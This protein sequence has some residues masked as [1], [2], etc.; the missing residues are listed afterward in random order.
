MELI[1]HIGS[2]KTGST[3]LQQTLR[4]SENYLKSK[5]VLYPR[6]PFH[7]NKQRIVGLFSGKV[8][9]NN[10]PVMFDPLRLRKLQRD[11]FASLAKQIKEENIQRLILS[12]ET[13][14]FP[15]QWDVFSEF[16]AYIEALSPSKITV[17]AYVRKPS[18][19]YPSRIQ[20][21]IK[22]ASRFAA[23]TPRPVRRIFEDYAQAFQ[24]E[25]IRPRVFDRSCLHDGDIVSDFVTEFLPDMGIERDRLSEP[26]KTNETMSAESTCLVRDYREKFHSNRENIF[27]PDT[28]Y[29]VRTLQKL[30][31]S[32][33]ASR[34]QIYPHIAEALDYQNTDLLWLRDEYGLEFPNYDYA[35][36][37]D[38]EREQASRDLYGAKLK[39]EEILVTDAE[40]TKKIAKA[41]L[42]TEWARQRRFSPF[43]S[44]KWFKERS[45][46][47]RARKKW[48]AEICSE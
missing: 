17:A 8:P 25:N 32:T 3:S 46:S 34:P 36:L 7:R 22:A 15:I 30:D 4:N 21:R 5:G 12:D 33:G 35:R 48:L 41:L 39:I 10:K 1:L 42:T 26:S 37:L 31:K 13:L 43:L 29:L 11:W 27:T 14:F 16:Q 28:R 44:P 9:R 40:L 47:L 24:R 20:Q 23:L 2:P 45:S 38:P 18:S 6:C 19:D